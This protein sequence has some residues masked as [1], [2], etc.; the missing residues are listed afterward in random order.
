MA[1]DADEVQAAREAA[2]RNELEAELVAQAKADDAA[3]EEAR[4]SW[5]KEQRE[6]RQKACQLI[7]A[8]L[9]LEAR[10][11]DAVDEARHRAWQEAREERERKIYTRVA[12][13]AQTRPLR[14]AMTAKWAE[15][16][17]IFTGWGGFAGEAPISAWELQASSGG[18]TR[19]PPQRLQPRRTR[20]N[21]QPAAARHPRSLPPH[22][23]R[24]S[25]P[26]RSRSLLVPRC[27]RRACGWWV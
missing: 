17:E 15:I 11:E 26:P 14:R 24:R 27:D 10:Q 7:C 23:A 4:L 3:A 12:A 20:R 5:E 19:S 16:E 8:R 6:A 9:V 25:L 22:A 1:K 2:K 18:G 13:D 21:L